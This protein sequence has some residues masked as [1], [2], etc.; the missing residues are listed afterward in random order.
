MLDSIQ[1]TTPL[2][3]FTVLI[4]IGGAIYTVFNFRKAVKKIN[5]FKANA[6]NKAYKNYLYSGSELYQP[7]YLPI[8]PDKEMEN[9]CNNFIVKLYSRKNASL[10]YARIA[11]CIEKHRFLLNSTLIDETLTS[12]KHFNVN[13]LNNSM[14]YFFLVDILQ[15][16][17]AERIKEFKKFDENNRYIYCRESG[18]FKNFTTLSYQKE[19]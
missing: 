2:P 3:I 10:I 19:K 1:F 11:E 15:K 13:F 12:N 17:N 4:T 16:N 7:S 18:Y 5:K 8:D 6:I 14:L 9:L